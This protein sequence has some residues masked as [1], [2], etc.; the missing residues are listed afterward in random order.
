MP[1]LRRR[2]EDIIELA[3]HFLKVYS[4]EMGKKIKGYTPEAAE[5]MQKYRWPGNV[6]ELK[7]VVERSV[8]LVRGAYVDVDE[9]KLSNL[10]TASDS[11]DVGQHLQGNPCSGT[12]ATRQIN[13][14]RGLL[15]DEN[16]CEYGP[17]IGRL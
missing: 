3:N 12:A 9:L 8:V 11:L 7:N 5:E 16:V 15:V 1:P 2:P 10:A 6:R 17:M 4:A 13:E 14:S